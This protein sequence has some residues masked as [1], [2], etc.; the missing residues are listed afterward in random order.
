MRNV[1]KLAG[2][3]VLGI[4]VAVAILVLAFLAYANSE[5]TTCWG[6]FSSGDAAGRAAA[7][8]RDAG[9]ETEHEYQGSR[10]AVTFSIGESGD[11]A[12]KARREFRAIV[13]RERGELGHP[14]DGCLERTQL[15]N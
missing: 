6:I 10:S 3:G 12:R 8:A 2:A 13:K 5:S 9:F 15:G 4:V 11:D 7:S 14:G 1:L